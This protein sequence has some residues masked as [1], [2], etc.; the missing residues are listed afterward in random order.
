MMFEVLIGGLIALIG[1][2]V[3]SSIS[4]AKKTEEKKTP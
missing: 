4:G 1:V 3:G 2:G